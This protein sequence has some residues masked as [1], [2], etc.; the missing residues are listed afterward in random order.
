[1]KIITFILLTFATL[2]CSQNIKYL[3]GSYSYFNV[4]TCNTYNFLD[5]VNFIEKFVSDDES[6]GFTIYGNYLILDNKLV[7]NYSIHPIDSQFVYSKIKRLQSI[8][9][10]KNLNINFKDTYSNKPIENGVIELY[11]TKTNKLLRVDTCDLNG[12]ININFKPKRSYLLKTKFI[13]EKNLESF[14]SN[15][16]K[17]EIYLNKKY[18]YNIQINTVK[19]TC[20]LWGEKKEYKIINLDSNN[21]EI[22][23]TT[24]P[25]DSYIYK[26]N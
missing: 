10:E 13:N 14:T 21:L 17:S 6:S 22:E 19:R 3:R 18:D 20:N 26:K 23:T 16:Y 8:L 9:E 12:S 11:D 25:F 4:W 7:L 5:S 1:M 24:K 2:S 15:Y